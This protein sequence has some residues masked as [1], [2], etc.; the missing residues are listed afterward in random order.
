MNRILLSLFFVALCL[1]SKAQQQD[2]NAKI[3]EVYADKAQELVFNNPDRLRDLNDILQNRLKIEEMAVVG[4]D[5][6]TKLSTVD[7]LNRYNPNLTRDDAFNVNTFNALK[8]NLNFFPRST[9]IYRVDNSN[10]VIIIEPQSIK[11]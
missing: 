7:L 10:Y 2:I 8:Y 9:V 4:E 3:Q 1:F 6:F 5:K 11:H